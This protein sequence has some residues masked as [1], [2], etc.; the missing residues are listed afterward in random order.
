MVEMKNG[1]FAVHIYTYFTCCG[2]LSSVEPVLLLRIVDTDSRQ[3]DKSG[4]SSIYVLQ[5][6]V[7][8]NTSVCVKKKAMA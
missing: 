2:V 8:V 3:R 5:F 6:G 4:A 7:V 1:C